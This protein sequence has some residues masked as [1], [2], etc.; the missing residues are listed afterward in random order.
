MLSR[1]KDKFIF[2]ILFVLFFA[3]C[4]TVYNP[5]TG[6]NEIIL[7]NTDSEVSLGRNLDM[8]LRKKLKILDDPDRLWRL[9]HIGN[10]L[11]SVS[12]RRD[13][14]YHFRVVKDK[15]LNAFAI[16][17]GFIYVNSGLMDIANDDELA[18]VLGH[19]IGHIAA[20]HSVKRLQ[21]SLGYQ[22]IMGIVSGVAD[23]QGLFNVMDVIF[24]VI[25]LGY[26]RKD[27]LLADSLA[28]RYIK[29]AGFNP[30][31]LITFFEKLKK[32]KELKGAD[33]NLVFLSSHPPIEER[34]K[35]IEKEIMSNP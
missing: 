5:A 31:G 2:I 6:K 25:N 21:A 10:K 19:E 28:V 24:D 32:E 1:L 27:E 16:P 29:R 9:N 22:L 33:F 4:V 20:R 18:G 15:E 14:V 23:Q 12:D 35:Q 3:G 17:G 30:Y 26:S 8:Q 13:L 34:I 11:A 7:I